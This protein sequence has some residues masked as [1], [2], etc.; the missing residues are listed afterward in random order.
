M[1][2]PR[3]GIGCLAHSISLAACSAIHLDEVPIILNKA[4]KVVTTFKKSHT[5]A[6]VLRKKQEVLLPD[7]KNKLLQ[8]CPTRRNSSYDMLERFNEQ[9]QVSKTYSITLKRKNV[10][11]KYIV[12]EV[13]MQF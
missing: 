1:E 9:S 3:I 13:M 2:V 4:R 12:L 10:G 7:K 8:D 6:T 11:F 5:A